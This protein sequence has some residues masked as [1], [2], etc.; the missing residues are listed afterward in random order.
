[1]PSTYH[2]DTPS[3]VTSL[4]PSSSPTLEESSTLSIALSSKPSNS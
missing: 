3:Y 2:A 4:Q 1:M